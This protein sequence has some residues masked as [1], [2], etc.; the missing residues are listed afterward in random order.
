MTFLVGRLCTGETTDGLSK[1]NRV[2]VMANFIV[3][4]SEEMQESKQK[5]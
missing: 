2:V 4:V 1:K 5:A 3:C